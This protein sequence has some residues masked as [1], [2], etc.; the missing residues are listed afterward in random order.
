[1]RW[2]ILFVLLGCA[3]CA[4]LFSAPAPKFTEPRLELRLSTATPKVTEGHKALWAVK[5]VNRGKQKV[6][7]V[8]PGGGSDCGWR[9]PIV[10]WVIDGKV[11]NVRIETQGKV[12]LE[13]GQ[14][15]KEEKVEL[16]PACLI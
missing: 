9:T 2:R 10:E 12:A 13:K 5:I 7:L 4:P 14:E 16:Q 8:Q 6:T 11:P 1:M 15:V 3:A